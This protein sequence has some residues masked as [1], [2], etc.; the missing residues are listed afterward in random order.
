MRFAFLLLVNII[1]VAFSGVAQ[2]VKS[3]T[4]ARQ[5][6]TVEITAERSQI[7]NSSSFI[8]KSLVSRQEIIRLGAWQVSDIAATIPGTFIKNYGG[9]GGLKTI[10][11][12]GTTSQQ[13][14]I[15]LDGVAL[16]SPANG[17]VD[18]SG[19]PL[20]LFDEIEISRSGNSALSGSGAVAGVINLRTS[21]QH[22]DSS[23]QPT[24]ATIGLTFGSFGELLTSAS[25]GFSS[26]GVHL[27]IGGEYV[28]SKGD[29][30]F[31]S[32]QFGN[33]LTIK[34][35]NSDFQNIGVFTS[36]DYKFGQW[37]VKH[38]LFLRD[39][40]RG[41]PGAVLQGSIEQTSARLNE[42][43]I[44]T[45]HS[46]T[47]N[48]SQNLELTFATS[49]RYSELD[50]KDKDALFRGPNGTNDLYLTRE[51]MFSAKIDWLTTFLY[52]GISSQ[53]IYSD[54]R[55][56][57]FQPDV[58]SFVER[59]TISLSGY[60]DKEFSLDSNFTFAVQLQSRLDIN[61]KNNSAFTPLFACIL[62]HKNLPLRL[63]TS[64]SYNFRLPSFNEMY[65]LNFG[66][67]SLKP[68]RAQSLN[69]GLVW[70][71]N[72]HCQVEAESFIINTNNQII[73]VPKSPI[74]WSAQNIGNVVSRGF[75]LS[76]GGDIIKQYITAKIAYSRQLTTDETVNS[77]TLGKQIPY[78]PEEIISGNIMATIEQSMVGFTANYSSFRYTLADNAIESIIPN[79]IQVN[80]FAEQKFDFNGINLSLRLDCT[81]LFNKQYE[82]ILNYPMPGRGFRLGMC[83]S[84]GK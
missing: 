51:L 56:N 37:S 13:T 63:R 83:G 27:N 22:L 12:R 43:E 50:Y 29:Y 19:L 11:L 69:L 14:V 79:Y 78:I 35:T 64:W 47:T 24:T 23:N 25:T 59:S 1:T 5:T 6:R 18:L 77:L 61:S 30:K 70:D 2:T 75:E 55:G 8:P 65:Y 41:S 67:A 49:A 40:K 38:K 66:T 73:A 16:T 7:L 82:V 58:G 21:A 72:S 20:T 68:E 84:L 10:S 26:L 36:A 31:Q 57:T 9:I 28:Q 48:I 15:M 4:N 80:L 44:L 39:T 76:G 53:I 62:R 60:A 45:I 81:N 33:E 54:L 17:T 32:L 42:Q 34:R 3:D 46:L 71:I 52:S 74:T